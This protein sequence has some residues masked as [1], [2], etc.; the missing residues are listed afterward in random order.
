MKQILSILIF[1]F[2]I[3]IYSQNFVNLNCEMGFEKIQ[4]ETKPEEQVSYKT[5]YSQ[6]VYGKESF[7][8]SQGIIV[9]KNI[10]DQ[11]SQN[12][13]IEIIGR[14]AVNKKFIKIIALQSCDAGE[15]YLQQTELTSEQK[16]YLSENL[17]VEMDIDLLKSL[18]KKEKKKQRKKR[19]LIETVSKKSCDKLSQL[20]K[21][22][23]TREQFTQIVSALS[24]EYAEK[25]M[26]VYEMSF[27]ESAGI[28]VTDMTN[29]LFS[30]CG[31]LKKLMQ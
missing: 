1:L 20:N 16:N 22:D 18:S 10:N 8:F 15:L 24:A 2:S 5:I 14:I 17:I 28:F 12:E 21:K 27:E 7:E 6:K 30:N 11:I 9:I 23:F 4:V 29:Y 31:A 25:T 3:T 19:D 13:I 26:N